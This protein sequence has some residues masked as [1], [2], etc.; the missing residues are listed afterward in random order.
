MAQ[1]NTR[2]LIYQLSAAEPIL[3]KEAE[4]YVREEIFEPAVNKLKR[5]FE[6]HPV[7]KE[8]DGGID[9]PNYSKTLI[10][11]NSDEG[12]NLYSF[13]GF[14]DGDDPLEAIRERLDEDHPDG[15]KLKYIK[16][17]QV[18]NLVFQ[19]RITPPNKDEIY[20]ETPMPWANGI[21]WAERVELGMP[22]VTR[23]LN[24]IG[25]R[26]SRSG[27]GIQVKSDLRSTRFSN[28]RFLSQIFG[29]FLARF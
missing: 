1:I 22:G 11:F 12:K 5:D 20:N 21:S 9:S 15:P 17:S 14:Y 28:R 8:I 13:I 4:N 2:E 24:K 7:T 18:R 27:G 6:K 29:D 23:F 10:G 19:F 16:G 26:S 3:A 25:L